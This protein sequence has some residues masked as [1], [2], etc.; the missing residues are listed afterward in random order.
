MESWI[1]SKTW[2]KTWPEVSLHL[3]RWPWPTTTQNT[4]TCLE[5]WQASREGSCLWPSMC[6]FFTVNL[7]DKSLNGF[8][9]NTSLWYHVLNRRGKELLSRQKIWPSCSDRILISR[10][11]A[12]LNISC[13][14]LCLC[15][16]PDVCFCVSCWETKSYLMVD[17]FLD[18]KLLKCLSWLLKKQLSLHLKTVNLK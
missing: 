6:F 15:V 18:Y 3:W 13:C 1:S 10:K 4:F 17:F 16:F 7:E 2:W 11:F 9:L 5:S 12:E 14:S 8:F